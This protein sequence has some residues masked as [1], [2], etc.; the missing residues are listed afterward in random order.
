M[1]GGWCGTCFPIQSFPPLFEVEK[2][3]KTVEES[4]KANKEKKKKKKK[5][6]N[7]NGTKLKHGQK[8]VNGFLSKSV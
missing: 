7:E 2:K 4:G 5:G 6:W 8:Y 3:H 1:A